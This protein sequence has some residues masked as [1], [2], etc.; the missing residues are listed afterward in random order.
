[1][2]G[3]RFDGGAKNA[4]NLWTADCPLPSELVVCRN[5]VLV[6]LS[7]SIR[8]YHRET[9]ELLWETE[10]ESPVF[11][12]AIAGDR[13]FASTARGRILAFAP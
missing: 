12:L 2:K 6:G 3:F 1:M 9:G 4:A 8:A 10:T 11:G 7:N 5:A 13:L